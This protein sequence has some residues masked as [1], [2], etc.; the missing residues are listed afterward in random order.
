MAAP[1]LLFSRPQLAGDNLSGFPKA[2]P[3]VRTRTDRRRQSSLSHCRSWY[4]HMPLRASTLSKGGLTKPKNGS[5]HQNRFYAQLVLGGLESLVVACWVGGS[6]SQ[7]SLMHRIFSPVV[8]IPSGGPTNGILTLRLW[9]L[10][11]TFCYCSH[12]GAT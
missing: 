10:F 6:M 11:C 5:R 4:V 12:I 8:R 3:R 9:P 1:L 2:R 7:C